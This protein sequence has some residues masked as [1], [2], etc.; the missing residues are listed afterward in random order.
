MDAVV[1]AVHE[2][3]A[4]GFEHANGSP[5]RIEGGVD[6]R[7]LVVE[8][9]TRGWWVPSEDPGALA[10]HGRGLILMRG[11]TDEAEVLVED[12]SVMIRLRVSRG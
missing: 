3:V 10:E 9:T 11:L 5:V 2:A 4:N 1:L 8:I 12:E 7:G 6:D